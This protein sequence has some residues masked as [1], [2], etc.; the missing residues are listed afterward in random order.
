MVLLEW[1]AFL[2]DH[3]H[4]G[5]S[6]WREFTPAGR[7]LGKGCALPRRYLIFVDGNGVFLCISKQSFFNLKDLYI[8]KHEH[9]NTVRAVIHAANTA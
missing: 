3:I 9:R 1:K 6:L 7:Y 8:T 5:W 2:H 4:E